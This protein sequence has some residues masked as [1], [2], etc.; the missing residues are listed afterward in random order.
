MF[1][2][3]NC[4]PGF[5]N[6]FTSTPTNI[7]PFAGSFPFNPFTNL[8]TN[9]VTPSFTPNFG[10]TPWNFGPTSLFNP[11]FQ[12]LP[13]FNPINSAPWLS[14]ATPWTSP[15][16][17]FSPF[18]SFNPINPW[19]SLNGLP[20]LTNPFNGFPGFGANPTPM[21][22]PMTPWGIPSMSNPFMP[23]FVGSPL[24]TY[25]MAGLPTFGAP[26]FGQ[27]LTSC[28]PVTGSP[29]GQP[30]PTGVRPGAPVQT[31]NGQPVVAPV[32]QNLNTTIPTTGIPSFNP[33]NLINPQ[34]T[35]LPG[36]NPVATISPWLAAQSAIN[37]FMNGIN[38]WFAQTP[39]GFNPFLGTMGQPVAVAP[40]TGI[41]TNT[42]VNAYG[43]PVVNPTLCREAA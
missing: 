27:P 15:V 43:Q 8:S 14:N 29:I 31:I 21:F 10:S 9:G 23:S 25:G 5:F 4:F 3:Q 35:Y 7:N 6:P 36:Y 28:T 41:P 37:P 22:N 38:P 40:F 18:N 11:G 2:T 39:W 12:T 24:N 19:S 17:T 20:S 42:P 33:L 16:N 32:M 34:F 13:S 26:I 1:N 30:I